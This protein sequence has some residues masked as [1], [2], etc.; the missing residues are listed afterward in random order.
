MNCNNVIICPARP[1]VPK[2]ESFIWEECTT[3]IGSTVNNIVILNGN[4]QVN[5]IIATVEN[6]SQTDSIIAT[7]VN[8][9]FSVAFNVPP[10]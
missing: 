6:Y 3:I 10:N 2:L 5:Q 1:I 7:F 4:F 9:D 8:G